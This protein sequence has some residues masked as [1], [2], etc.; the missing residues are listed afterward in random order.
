MARNSDGISC[1]YFARSGARDSGHLD[2]QER[3]FVGVKLSGDFWKFSHDEPIECSVVHCGCGRHYSELLGGAAGR[4]CR[5]NDERAETQ[6]RRSPDANDRG[7]A[8]GPPPKNYSGERNSDKRRKQSTKGYERAKA[9]QRHWCTGDWCR[10][11]EHHSKHEADNR[12]GVDNRR[13]LD[14]PNEPEKEIRGRQTE[15]ALRHN[16]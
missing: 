15:D 9:A 11:K 6:C 14:R 16:E 12:C 3:S 7:P 10:T 2:V 5:V 8:V 1:N 4:D 13:L